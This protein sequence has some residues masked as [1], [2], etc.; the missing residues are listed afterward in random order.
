[1]W[2]EVERAL[3]SVSSICKQG[4]AV[5]SNA[6]G[7]PDGSYMCHIEPGER[8]ELQHEDGVFLLDTKVAPSSRQTRPFWGEDGEHGEL[9]CPPYTSLAFNPVEEEAEVGAGKASEAE[10]L[11]NRADELAGGIEDLEEKLIREEGRRPI[12]NA[13]TE[14]EVPKHSVNH[15]P[16]KPWCPYCAVASGLREPHFRIRKGVPDVNAK[17]NTF[18]GRQWIGCI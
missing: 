15:P 3:G 18:P 7:D 11:Q 14:P 5:A 2:F 8:L 16:P 6:P 10:E 4:H 13:A 12:V 1:M 17:M 9:G